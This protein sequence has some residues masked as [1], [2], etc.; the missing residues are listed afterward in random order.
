[1][2]KYFLSQFDELESQRVD[3][4]NRVKNLPSE[5]FNYAPPGKWSISQI[6]THILVAEQLS[7]LYMKKKSLGVDQLNN[8]GI[9]AALRSVVLK[10]S[11]RIP[12][13]KFKAPKVVLDHTP[14]AL[15]L[16]ELT[17]QWEKHREKLRTFLESI[18]EKNKK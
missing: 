13:I 2:N 15:S 3:I 4:I 12:A 10:I 8:S 7:V 18:E 5:K 16:D 6:L 11:Q 14:P 9:T 1:V 17:E